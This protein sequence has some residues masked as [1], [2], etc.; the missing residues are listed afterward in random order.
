VI[1]AVSEDIGRDR[2]SGAI[3][4][5]INSSLRAQGHRAL[6]KKD[7]PD[8]ARYDIGF[9]NVNVDLE[10]LVE[11]VRSVKE[12]RFCFHG[13]S[14]TG[15][16]AFARWLAEQAEMPLIVKRASDLLDPFVGGTEQKIAEAFEEAKDTKFA[17][18]ID[19]FDSFLQDRRAAQRNWEIS[20]VNEMLVQIEEFRG[21]FIATTNRLNAMDHAILRR[22]DLK[23]EFGCLSSQQL[24]SV[25]RQHCHSLELGDPSAEAIVSLRRLANT[26]IGD[27]AVIKRQSRLNKIASPEMLLSRLREECAFRDEAK[28]PIGFLN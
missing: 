16:T 11:S 14:G 19:E 3:E 22:F 1:K 7:K 4:G 13:A 15:K 20:Q 28:R 18:L 27:F 8:A 25:F 23:I 17:L 9:V 10:R 24:L 21:V 6:V 26:T 5:L 2:V 12:G